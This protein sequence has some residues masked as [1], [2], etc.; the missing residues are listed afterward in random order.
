MEKLPIKALRAT[1]NL[2]QKE[3]AEKLGVN[4]N[5]YMNWENYKTYPN[6]PQLIKLSEVFECSL[7]TFYF[8]KR[9]S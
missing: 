4:R 1:K 6:I 5:T 7:D 3:V 8:P 2:T 9:A